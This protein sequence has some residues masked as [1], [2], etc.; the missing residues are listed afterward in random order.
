VSATGRDSQGPARTALV[1]GASSGF[2]AAIAR[3]FGALG[4]A[5]ALG[6]RRVGK[7]EEVARDVEKAGGRG[8]VQ[9]LDVRE[10]DSIDAFVSAAENTFGPLDVVVSN[11]GIG[12]PGH[13]HELSE[14]DLRSEVDTNLMGP[15]LL[16]RRVV[17]GMIARHTGDLVFVTSLNAVLPRP[18]QPGYTASKAGLEALVRV[19]QME[20][21]GTGVRATIVRPG[22]SK[23]EMGWDWNPDVL[24]RML[25]AWNR[26]GVLRHHRYLAPEPVANAVVQVVTAAPGTHLDLVQINPEAPVEN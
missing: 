22:P 11:A 5:V 17:P 26:F 1:T 9:P 24:K 6:A 2:G 20:L 21:E 25:T 8:F 7:L 13:L 3:A 19:L 23:T 15:M 10:G 16:A 18:L 4:W 12:I 14:E